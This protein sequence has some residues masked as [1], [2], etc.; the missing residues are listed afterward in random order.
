MNKIKEYWDKLPKTV[1]V[2]FYIAFS[3]SLKELAVYLGAF[4]DSFFADYLVGLINIV[5][6]FLEESVPAVRAKLSR[7]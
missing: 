5:I 4:E 2:F 6:V 3:Y 1:K 7:K